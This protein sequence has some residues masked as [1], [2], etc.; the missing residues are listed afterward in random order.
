[1]TS[2]IKAAKRNT[3][4]LVIRLRTPRPTKAPT[5]AHATYPNGCGCVGSL[6]GISLLLP[7]FELSDLSL[8]GTT[9]PSM[10][11]GV[12][13]SCDPNQQFFVHLLGRT[14]DHEHQVGFDDRVHCIGQTC[15]FS[16]AQLH[17][18]SGAC[19]RECDN[20]LLK[21]PFLSA[22]QVFLTGSWERGRSPMMWKP[23]VGKD[24]SGSPTETSV[25]DEAQASLVQ[26]PISNSIRHNS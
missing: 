25:S 9:Q 22:T 16:V 26:P 12:I 24:T 23:P 10:A 8:T 15:D 3:T 11:L 2:R 20:V 1:M 18:Q 6:A 19:N 17:H 5:N 14:D 7:V 13:L 4:P 21:I